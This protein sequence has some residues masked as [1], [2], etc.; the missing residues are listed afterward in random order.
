MVINEGLLTMK[1]ARL[2]M[3]VGQHFF[4]IHIRP[5]IPVIKIGRQHYFRVDDLKFIQ[6]EI[7]KPHPP[8]AG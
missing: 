6:E 8:D 7:R 3:G 5:K 4:N 1:E 2:S